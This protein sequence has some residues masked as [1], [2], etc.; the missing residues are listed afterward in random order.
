MRGL[1]IIREISPTGGRKPD[2]SGKPN[3]LFRQEKVPKTGLSGPFYA[4]LDA[5]RRKT[6]LT[7]AP[8]RPI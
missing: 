1:D 6:N 5:W 3:P 2:F 4:L 8:R 7:D